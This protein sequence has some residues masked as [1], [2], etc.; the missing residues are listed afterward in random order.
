MCGWAYAAVLTFFLAHRSA[1]GMG[2]VGWWALFCICGALGTLGKG[3]PAIIIPLGTAAFFLM[4]RRDGRLAGKTALLWALSIWGVTLLAKIPAMEKGVGLLAVVA[5]V[6]ASLVVWSSWKWFVPIWRESPSR[7]YSRIGYFQV[8][9]ILFAAVVG[10]W[11]IPYRLNAPRETSSD[12]LITQTLVRYFAGI[13]HE[14]PI[15]YFES[16][17][18]NLMPWTLFLFVG[19][20]RAWRRE[21]GMDGEPRRLLTTWILFTF[22]FFSLTPGKRDHYLLPFVPA[23]ALLCG[24]FFDRLAGESRENLGRAFTV[25][26]YVN[27]AIAAVF[28]IVGLGFQTLFVWAGDP[29]RGWRGDF[30]ADHFRGFDPGGLHAWALSLSGVVLFILLLRSTR[31]RSVWGVFV[32]S[33]LLMGSANFHLNNCVLP[34][35]DPVKSGRGLCEEIEKRRTD[36]EEEVGIYDFFRAEYILFG[37]YFLKIIDKDT[38]N[39]DPGLHAFLD[40][41]KR[42]LLIMRSEYFDRLRELYPEL[43]MRFLFKTK[44]GHR[45]VTV[46]DNKPDAA[47]Q[48]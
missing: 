1:P 11:Y 7:L 6:F 4:W 19:A 38:E 20:I 24:W 35:L 30:L 41:P 42:H 26:A 39:E 45:E 21:G 8:G 18:Y 34:A 15:W 43:P 25:P 31:R 33:A 12:T 23:F 32:G 10:I 40:T 2:R 9:M 22:V 37:D 17:P 36:S 3:P 46:V 27:V 47:S 29:A 28:A 13:G 48:L 16:V 5:V 44:V 14:H